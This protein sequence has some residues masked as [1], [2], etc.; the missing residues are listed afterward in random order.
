M[1][2]LTIKDNG[3]QELRTHSMGTVLL[4]GLKHHIRPS[5]KRHCPDCSALWWTYIPLFPIDFNFRIVHDKAK[6]RPLLDQPSEVV[7]LGCQWCEKWFYMEML[8]FLDLDRPSPLSR[9]RSNVMRR[10]P[11]L[12][13][14]H[15]SDEYRDEMQSLRH[16]SCI[17]DGLTI[18]DV[19]GQIGLLS[20]WR[21][22]AQCR[23]ERYGNQK[24]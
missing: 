22:C 19:A 18:F 13:A 6:F 8:T 10:Y 3:D 17:P 9:E 11:N 15:E 24:V 16:G 7:M 4:S 20:N 2:R 14:Y 23:T 5:S 12:N 1:N 21:N